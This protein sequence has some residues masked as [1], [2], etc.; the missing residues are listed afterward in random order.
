[1]KLMAKN[2]YIKQHKDFCEWLERERESMTQ[3]LRDAADRFKCAL[4]AAAHNPPP[5][6]GFDK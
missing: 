5:M 6:P 3:E 1:M 4:W 2:P